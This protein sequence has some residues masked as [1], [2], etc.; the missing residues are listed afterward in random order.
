MKV[1]KKIEISFIIPTFNEEGNI[2]VLSSRIQ[3]VVPKEISYEI[4]VCK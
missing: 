2:A 3:E 4:L 1:K